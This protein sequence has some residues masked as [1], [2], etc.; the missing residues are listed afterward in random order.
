[1]SCG[2]RG[3]AFAVASACASA[4]HAIGLAFH[5]VRSGRCQCAVTGGAEA[6]ITFG[7]MKGWEAHARDSRPTPAGRSRA[8]A[9][10]W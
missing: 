3:P 7:T 6:C 8:T 1:M 10:A 4:T 9:R 5:M 2:L